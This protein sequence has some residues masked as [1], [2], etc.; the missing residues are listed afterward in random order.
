MD[1]QKTGSVKGYSPKQPF[2]STSLIRPWP[3]ALAGALLLVAIVL[4]ISALFISTES[5]TD[6]IARTKV[7][8]IGY[9]V[10]APFAFTDPEGTV[11]GESPEVARAVWQRLGVAHIEW[12]RTDFASLIPQ[13][14]AG[15]FD[16]I[17]AGLFIRPDR[18]QLV[19]FTSPSLCLYPALLVH[20]GNPLDI[21]SYKDIALQEKTRLAVIQGAVEREEALRAGIPPERI[22]IYP[23][24]QLALTALNNNLVDGLSLSGP[25]IRRLAEKQSNFQQATP[26]EASYAPP[27]CGAFAFRPKDT[28]LQQRFDQTLRQFLGSPEHMQ[29]LHRLGLNASDL[30]SSVTFGQRENE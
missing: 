15:R 24:I 25:T 20:W 10:E 30:P 28:Q 2:A 22:D 23:N 27:G 13:L 26:F 9:A 3:L 21:H 17:A 29:I 18:K 1:S 19:A 16:Q 14:R 11:T 4:G 6:R 7:V 5:T 12:I 8:R